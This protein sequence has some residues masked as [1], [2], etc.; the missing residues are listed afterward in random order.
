MR[1]RIFLFLCLVSLL[2]GQ[3]AYA[4]KPQP[5]HP[6]DGKPVAPSFQLKDS[7][8]KLHTLKDHRGEVVII[9]FWAT[10][11]PPCRFEL[12]SMERAYREL[13]KHNIEILAINVG[14]SEDIIFTFTADYPVT[15]PL[16]L[17]RDSA[18]IDRYP[19]VGLPT[20]FVIDTQGRLV[21]RAIGT[22]EWDNPGLLEKI[23]TLQ[24]PP[25]KP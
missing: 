17:D 25:Q 14:E 22:R 16:L 11:C 2:A 15:F 24:K 6:V 18:V 23:I 4:D 13:Q 3:L 12:P 7:N 21:Y 1:V 19:V 10:W 9:N 5:L 20:T 8:G